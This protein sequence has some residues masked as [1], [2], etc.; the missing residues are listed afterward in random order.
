ME[1]PNSEANQIVEESMPVRPQISSDLIRWMITG[2][3]IAES[4]EVE[5]TGRKTYNGKQVIVN[6]YKK[7]LINDTGI[8][9]IK[10]IVTGHIGKSSINSN[11]TEDEILMIMRDI[12]RNIVDKLFIHWQDWEVLKSDCS[13]IRGVVENNVF[14]AIKR[15]INGDQF[16]KWTGA[17]KRTEVSSPIQKK[18]GFLGWMGLK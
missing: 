3:E 8:N 17:V 14:F 5:L 6:P 12:N 7:R 2:D 16:N 9:A 15:A 10:I 18:N 11:L 4:I 1:M 13:T